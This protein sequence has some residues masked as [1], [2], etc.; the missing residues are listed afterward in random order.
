MSIQNLENPKDENDINNIQFEKNLIREYE[1]T[2][3]IHKNK[4]TGYSKLL[5]LKNTIFI[6]IFSDLFFWVNNFIY[7]A[8]IILYFC[9]IQYNGVIPV[10]SSE[11]ISA[12]NINGFIFFILV[13]FISQCYNRYNQHFNNVIDINLSL[14]K[15]LLNTC[16]NI[17]KKDY[18]NIEKI[19][20]V[21]SGITIIHV[22]SYI[23]PGVGIYTYENLLYPL[24]N[25]YSLITNDELKK[26]KNIKNT[27]KNQTIINNITFNFPKYNGN[28][29]EKGDLVTLYSKIVNLI[30]KSDT[31][32]PF[33]Y[34]HFIYIITTIYLFLF[35]I[36][37]GLVITQQSNAYIVNFIMG[38]ILVFFLN[39][40]IIGIRE[41]GEILHDP[42]DADVDDFPATITCITTINNCI[43]ILYNKFIGDY[44]GKV[45]DEMYKIPSLRYL[46]NIKECQIV[47]DE[48]LQQRKLKPTQNFYFSQYILN[49]T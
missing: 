45:N 24:I 38:S 2:I 42:Y 14:E 22:L 23:K 28:Y 44:D 10:F 34:N 17:D 16:F 18:E 46:Y 35:S 5:L 9:N 3:F 25:H 27:E 47:I 49:K 19:I 39:I 8:F 12:A 37:N 31:P 4:S 40:L 48:K 20:N 32:I 21:F 29:Y 43:D 30:K 13:F 6:N 1:N 36:Y 7:N 11:L 33:V 15:L 26:L 41:I